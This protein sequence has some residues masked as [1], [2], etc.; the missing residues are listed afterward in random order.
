MA[1]QKPSGIIKHEAVLWLK[2]NKIQVH[3]VTGCWF[4]PETNNQPR[5]KITIT[6]NGVT[7]YV[8]AYRYFKQHQHSDDCFEWKEGMQASHT[9]EDICAE[10]GLQHSRCC[11]P[12]HIVSETGQQNALR[13]EPR[14][15]RSNISKP[16]KTCPRGY[17]NEQKLDFFLKE[18]TTE[19][20]DGC[21][22]WTDKIHEGAQYP[23]KDFIVDGKKKKRYLHR[24]VAA[25]K[26]SKPYD[27]LPL[28]RHICNNRLC[29]NSDHLVCNFDGTG[30]QKNAIDSRA[31]SANTKLNEKLVISICEDLQNNSPFMTRAS[32]IVWTAYWQEILQEQGIIVRNDALHKIARKENWKDISKKYTWEW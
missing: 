4:P 3:P 6:E 8:Y 2:E 15:N 26:Y 14:T 9:C 13:A 11:N 18:M 19:N 7:K 24:V 30:A 1:K 23:K 31:T 17:T 10:H 22:I 5:W 20:D 27:S 21:L 29:L 12:D 25:R 28:V 16:S 32:K